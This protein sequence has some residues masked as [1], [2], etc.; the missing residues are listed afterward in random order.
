MKRD[1]NAACW[2]QAPAKIWHTMKAMADHQAGAVR[3]ADLPAA[4]ERAVAN[5]V[6]WAYYDTENVWPDVCKDDLKDP[7]G[8]IAEAGRMIRAAGL[9]SL[10]CCYWDSLPDKPVLPYPRQV[11]WTEWW[12]AQARAGDA[13]DFQ[14]PGYPQN[15]PSHFGELTARAAALTRKVNPDVEF[16]LI[17]MIEYMSS[18]PQMLEAAWK[19]AK[20]HVD[21]RWVWR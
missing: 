19:A 6:G 11:G 12:K 7:L 1:L 8:S 15:Q 14:L 18:T 10:M 3:L 17:N 13:V 4:I 2:V 9:K 5:N 16:L 21:G 20:P